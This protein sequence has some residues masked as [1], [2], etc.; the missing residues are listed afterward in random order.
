[1]FL[2]NQSKFTTFANFFL[3]RGVPLLLRCNL[4]LFREKTFYITKRIPFPL[5]RFSSFLGLRVTKTLCNYLSTSSSIFPSRFL[6]W[7][8]WQIYFQIFLQLLLLTL[9]TKTEDMRCHALSIHVL[10][11]KQRWCIEARPSGIFLLR[12]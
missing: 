1:M 3:K 10:S 6:F 9:V 4:F 7:T 5:H 11:D 8:D 2:H 12:K